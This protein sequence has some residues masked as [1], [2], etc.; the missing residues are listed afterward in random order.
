MGTYRLPSVVPRGD[1]LCRVP[2]SSPADKE[3]DKYAAKA[4]ET[5]ATWLKHTVDWYLDH[6]E[7]IARVTSGE[8]QK[9]YDSVYAQAWGRTSAESKE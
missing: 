7:W 2:F 8:Y 5:F 1:T 3:P 4:R 6:Q 9:Y